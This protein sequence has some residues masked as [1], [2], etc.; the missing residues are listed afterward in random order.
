VLIQPGV[1]DEAVKVSSAQS[2][3]WIRGMNRN[4]VIVDDQH[5]AGN[6]SESRHPVG[7]PAPPPQPTMPDPCAGVPRNP[8]C[9]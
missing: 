1:Y 4:S 3:I 6:E 5:K 8:L 2:G 7:Q 9:P